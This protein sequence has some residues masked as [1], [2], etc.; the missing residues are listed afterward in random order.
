MLSDFF[1]YTFKIQGVAGFIFDFYEYGINGN[2]N[3]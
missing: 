2:E 1:E 3:S